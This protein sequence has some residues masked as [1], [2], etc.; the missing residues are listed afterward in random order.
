L[1]EDE[2]DLLNENR[3]IGSSKRPSKRPR[4]HSGSVD[5]DLDLDM[6]DERAK[7]KNMFEDDEGMMDEDDDDLGDFI[8]EDEEPVAGETEEERRQRRR[9]EKLKRREAAKAR[10]EASGVDKA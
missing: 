6:G 10:P 5:D 8:E 4:R 2:L 3:G 9:E 7:L 1:S